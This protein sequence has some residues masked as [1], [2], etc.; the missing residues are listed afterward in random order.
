MIRYFSKLFFVLIFVLISCV[1]ENKTSSSATGNEVN[2]KIEIQKIFDSER[3]PN[4]VVATDGSIIATWG[5]NSY[6]VRRSEDGGETWGPIITVADPG[7]QG[8]GVIVDENSGDILAFVEEGHPPSP[9]TIYRS[10]D[11]GITWTPVEATIHPDENGNVPSMHMNERGITLKYGDHAGRLIRPTRSYGEGNDREY[12]ESHYTN[13]IYSDDGGYTWHTSAPFPAYGTGEATLEE[14]SDGRIY[15]NS[16][17]HLSTDG[18]NPRMRYIA[19]SEDGGE[20]WEDLSVSEELPDGAQHIDYGLMAGLVRLPVDGQD[21]LLFSNIDM[22]ADQVDTEGR[23]SGRER[24]TVWASFDG[25]QTWPVK[26]LVEEGG[27]AYSSMTAGREGTPSEGWIYLFYE[28]GD[29]PDTGGYV[30]RF[31][32]DWVTNGKDW[33]TFLPE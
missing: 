12:W 30:A 23:T 26:R 8:G 33:R 21:I 1:S 11:H 4:I 20:T 22:P 7:F 27:F 3:F 16:R 32:L 17:R 13:A 31:N 24:G 6:Q 25:G 14:L 18:L 28:G 15:Y 10:T 2:E 9:V 29:H 19:W 5:S